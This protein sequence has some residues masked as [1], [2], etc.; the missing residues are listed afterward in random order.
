MYGCV[1]QFAV[2]C[3]KGTATSARTC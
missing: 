2:I 1:Q 3:Q